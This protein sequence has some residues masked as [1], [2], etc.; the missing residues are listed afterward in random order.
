MSDLGGQTGR[1]LTQTTPH[2]HPSFELA[3]RD[4]RSP[5][6]VVDF[7][8]KVG[9]PGRTRTFDPLLRSSQNDITLNITERSG[10]QNS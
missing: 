4:L 10:I 5:M 6:Q 9:M 2:A 8:L 1:N 7:V 3:I